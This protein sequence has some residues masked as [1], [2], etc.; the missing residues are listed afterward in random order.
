[1]NR[2][3]NLKLKDL[4]SNPFQQFDLWFDD[5]KKNISLYPEAMSL[6]TLGKDGYPQTRYVLLRGYKPPVFQFFTNYNSDK[7]QQLIE[8]P[9]ASLLFYW[10]ELGRQIRISGTVKKS[11][12]PDSD[13]YWA[14]RPN[15]SRIH[16]MA[17]NQSHEVQNFQDFLNL[18]NELEK[19]HLGENIP[20]PKNWGGFDFT[21]QK[22]EFWQEGE[23]RL[24]HR[25]VYSKTNTNDWQ[26]KQLYP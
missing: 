17:S 10:K 15:E 18:V 21:A 24:H 2:F 8:H 9:K 3:Q 14:T 11:S 20:R 4:K 22:F 7:G 25:F 26:I 19:K 6:A 12:D 16:A 13:A 1:M 23:F 5:A